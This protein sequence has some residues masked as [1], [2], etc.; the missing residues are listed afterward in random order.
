[1]G[2]KRMNIERYVIT[3]KEIKEIAANIS[4][5]ENLKKYITSIMKKANNSQKVKS[6]KN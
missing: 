5:L 6:K 3:Q 4:E 1:M 2:D